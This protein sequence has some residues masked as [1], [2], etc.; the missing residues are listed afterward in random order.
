MFYRPENGHGLPR[1]PLKACV[2]PRPI[3]WISSLSADG[4]PNL[5]PYSYFNAVG[6]NPPLVAYSSVGT[7]AGAPKD[8]LSNVEATGEFVVN[9]AT[10]ALFDAVV[11]TGAAFPADVD[12]IAETG[13]TAAASRIVTPPRVAESPIQLEC[14]LH[15]VMDLPSD[16]PAERV[17]L[18]VG[19]I[20]GVHIAEDVLTDGHIDVAKLRPLARMGY[21]D[22]T[23]VSETF[24]P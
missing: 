2:T 20:V 4:V 8:T 7:N 11:R 9:V 24:Q 1:D 3:G 6:F 14:R 19:R 10:E 15:A 22:Y 5:A 23:A 18:V 16:D 17:A 21:R 13:L 12:E